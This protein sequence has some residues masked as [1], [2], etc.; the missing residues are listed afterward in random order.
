MTDSDNRMV[1]ECYNIR[2]N[3]IRQAMQN[4]FDTFEKLEAEMRLG[5]LCSA[6]IGD[7]KKVIEQIKKYG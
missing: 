1:C 2:I 4:G 5:V 3:D 7:A 6:C